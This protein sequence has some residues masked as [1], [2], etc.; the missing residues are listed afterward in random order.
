MNVRLTGITIE[1]FQKNIRKY[2]KKE[3]GSYN[4]V[5]QPDNPQDKNAIGVFYRRS[6][7]GYIPEHAA[8]E[9]AALMDSGKHL[10]AKFVRLI[11][12]PMSGIIGISVEIFEA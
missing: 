12:F 9:L 3:T 4:L 2:G 5:R 6:Q 8:A 11:T 7:L 10:K 1:A